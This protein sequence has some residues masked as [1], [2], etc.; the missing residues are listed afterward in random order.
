MLS[1]TSGMKKM[2]YICKA[3]HPEAHVLHRCPSCAAFNAST[4]ETE[5]RFQRLQT[6]VT[7]TYAIG[8]THTCTIGVS[9]TPLGVVEAHRKE[10]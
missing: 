9:H 4:Q 10:P 1:E 8:V 2:T 7:Q 6:G 3:K 5:G